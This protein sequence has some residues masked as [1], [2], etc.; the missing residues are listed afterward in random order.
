MRIDFSINGLIAPKIDFRLNNCKLL[1]RITHLVIRIELTILILMPRFSNVLRNSIINFCMFLYLATCFLRGTVSLLC[2]L[3]AVS[4]I[5]VPIY[6]YLYIIS[7]GDEIVWPCTLFKMLNYFKESASSYLI[8][9]IYKELLIKLFWSV[10]Y[11]YRKS[12]KLLKSR[13]YATR[14][15][16]GAHIYANNIDYNKYTPMCNNYNW[17]KLKL[18]L[19]SRQF[20]WQK[21]T[22]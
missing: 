11:S 18:T 19:K 22:T 3:Q 13:L 16:V 1:I 4:K 20:S 6:P 7:E 9:I 17:P 21:T 10:S 12:S 14:G 2:R 8:M 5:H 15:P